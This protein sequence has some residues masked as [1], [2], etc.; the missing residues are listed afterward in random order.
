M[1]D[2]YGNAAKYERQKSKLDEWPTS[3][4]NR[5]RIKSYLASCVDHLSPGRRSADLWYL[6]KLFVWTGLS[7][8]EPY[9]RK[10]LSSLSIADFERI[11]TRLNTEIQA[12]ETYRKLTSHLRNLY[13]HS[14]RGHPQ[15][16]EIIQTLFLTDRPSSVG[17]GPLAVGCLVGGEAWMGRSRRRG[18]LCSLG[19]GVG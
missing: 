9:V 7:K 10:R 19:G 12:Q 2:L 5:R 6:R 1:V 15:R 14:F 18:L 3:P 4:E 16:A 17:D 8:G 13:E 11:R